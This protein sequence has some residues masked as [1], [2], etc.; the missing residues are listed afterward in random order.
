MRHKG[1]FLENFAW[2]MRLNLLFGGLVP[3]WPGE[4]YWM[5]RKPAAP[6]PS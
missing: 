4:I 6:S 1:F 5:M 3:S 2:W